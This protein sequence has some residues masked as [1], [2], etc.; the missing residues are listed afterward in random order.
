MYILVKQYAG[1]DE[2]EGFEFV[3]AMAK[4]YN[5]FKD[6]AELLDKARANNKK[7]DEYT[8]EVN[9]T[10]R[11]NSE[12]DANGN[13]IVNR[14]PNGRESYNIIDSNKVDTL[15][16]ALEKKYKDAIDTFNRA[17]DKFNTTLEEEVTTK[18]Y[19]IKEIDLPKAINGKQ[20]RMINGFIEWDK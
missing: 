4:N 13:V 10:I 2:L 15:L 1:L 19:M 5:S 11:A 17:T 16:K 18:I 7:Y 8:N 20:L 14:L 6:E 3:K 9:G 12:L